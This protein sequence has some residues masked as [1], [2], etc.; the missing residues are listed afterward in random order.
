MADIELKYNPYTKKVEKCTHN[1]KD[2]DL[3]SSVWGDQGKELGV[4]AGLFIE[5]IVA[6]C[7]DDDYSINFEGIERDFN[8]LED[9]AKEYVEKETDNY[10]EKKIKIA[11][12]ANNTLTPTEKFDELK[13]LFNKMQQETPFPLCQ[14]SCRLVRWENEIY[15]KF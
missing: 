14:Y 5:K 2:L 6:R 7:N 15:N 11:V 10:G 12:H 13:N 8:F 4:W 3:S 1:G 9:A